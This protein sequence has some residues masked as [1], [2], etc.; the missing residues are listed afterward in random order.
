MELW[1]YVFGLMD[2]GQWLLLWSNGLMDNDY[3]EDL[4]SKC[5]NLTSDYDDIEIEMM[6]FPYACLYH[7]HIVSMSNLYGSC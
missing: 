5:S 1:S 4:V 6:I 3:W 7:L 2:I